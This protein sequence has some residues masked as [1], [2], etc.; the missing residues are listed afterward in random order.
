MK[1]LTL[2]EVERMYKRLKDETDDKERGK[3]LY[4][5]KRCWIK[6]CPICDLY[7]VLTCYDEKDRQVLFC[8][9][10]GVTWN[11]ACD[12]DESETEK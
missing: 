9:H 10:C 2:R 7:T 6:Q 11:S 3:I 1:K 12:N 5:F 8:L 4:P